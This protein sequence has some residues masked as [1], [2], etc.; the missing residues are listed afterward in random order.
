[1]ADRSQSCAGE[2]DHPPA[3]EVR[4]AREGDLTAVR[5]VVNWAIENTHYNFHAEPL[6][7]AHWRAEWAAGHERHP[8]LV[9]ERAGEVVGV[10]YAGRLKARRAYDWAV[11]TTVYVSHLHHRRGV[12]RVLYGVLL[13]ILEAQGFHT[14]IGVIALPNP[15]S[16][17]LHERCGFVAAGELPRIGWKRDRW[18]G[19][20]HWQKMLQHETHVP[21]EP[22]SVAAALRRLDLEEPA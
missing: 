18:W 17:A 7:T 13:P 19:V 11:E 22:L 12:G 20:G 15:G 21:E 10:A 5:D 14:A 6:G 1:M 2:I 9:A 16:V 3:T 4:V 8:W